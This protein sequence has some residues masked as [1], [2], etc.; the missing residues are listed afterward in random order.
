MTTAG[1]G[2]LMNLISDLQ[3]NVQ[4]LKDQLHA[5]REQVALLPELVDA[6]APLPVIS[7][8]DSFIEQAQHD[9]VAP[10]LRKQAK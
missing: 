5:T 7:G 4:I 8:T 9:H 10:Y 2:D 3:A 6:D 1:F